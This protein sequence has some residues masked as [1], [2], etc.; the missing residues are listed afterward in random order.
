MGSD[1]I[2]RDQV[3]IA[4]NLLTTAGYKNRSYA[5]ISDT[6]YDP[7]YLVPILSNVDLLYH[8][9][10][11]LHD[12]VDRA[13]ETYHSTSL[14]AAQIAK[15]AN[16]KRLLIGHFSA[17]YFDASPLLVEA[18]SMFPITLEAVEGECIQV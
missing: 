9:T 18:K 14:Q 8:E 10:T 11:F 15:A 12:R 16:V 7:D 2:S 1:Y 4:N 3:I 5:Y 17:R 6:V 13:S